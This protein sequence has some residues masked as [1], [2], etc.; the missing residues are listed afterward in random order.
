MN[1]NVLTVL[2]AAIL[3]CTGTALAE[4]YTDD[5]DLAWTD[6][7][8]NYSLRALHQ[9][10]NNWNCTHGGKAWHYLTE[11]TGYDNLQI[12]PSGDIIGDNFVGAV[13]TDEPYQ[14]VAIDYK[15]DSGTGPYPWNFALCLNLDYTQMG[16]GDPQY[17]LVGHQYAIHLRGGS[18]MHVVK[19]ADDGTEEYTSGWA[20]FATPS[21]DLDNEVW[22]RIELEKRYN[23]ITGVVREK[24][25]GALVGFGR[26]TDLG[27]EFTGGTATI[28]GYSAMTY[29]LDNFEFELWDEAPSVCGDNGTEYLAGDVDLD[30]YVNFDDIAVIAEQWLSS[31][32]PT[33][34]EYL[35]PTPGETSYKLP[36]DT[37][38][39]VD[40][41]L[42]DWPA[43]AEWI[44]LDQRYYQLGNPN[45]VT[46]A[47]FSARWDDVN[48]V[49]YAAVIV[50]ETVQYF[51]SQY[52]GSDTQDHIEVYSQGSGA[53][54][55][56]W[57][58]EFDVAQ[59]YRTAPDT[60]TDGSSVWNG[61]QWSV[62]GTGEAIAPAVG[63]VSEV[64]VTGSVTTYEL[65]IP[66]FD[67][68]EGLTPSGSTVVTQL[69]VGDVIGLD[70]IA[71]TIDDFV[72]DYGYL[73]ENMMTGKWNDA[74]QFA[75]YTLV[76]DL[77]CG[78]VGYATADIVGL[79]CG[80]NFADFVLM[81]GQWFNCTDP[82]NNDCDPYWTPEEPPLMDTRITYID[83]FNYTP[84]QDLAGTANWQQANGVFY[85]HTVWAAAPGE[86][87]SVYGET[88]GD[89]AVN[90]DAFIAAP[91]PTGNAYERVSLEFK[92]IGS[93]LGAL[94]LGLNYDAATV[95]PSVFWKLDVNQY[96]FLIAHDSN[97]YLAKRDE[98]GNNLY[99]GEWS[100][101][102]PLLSV[103]TWYRATLEKDGTTITAKVTSL[104]GL[105][106]YGQKSFEDDGTYGPMLEGGRPIVCSGIY[107]G[108]MHA[109]HFDNFE[110]E[111]ELE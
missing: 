9:V 1:K 47:K 60:D 52:Y 85:G 48:D 28:R 104:D 12:Y 72:T 105:T 84:P 13:H 80:V 79:D 36:H 68:Y 90:G 44:A 42:S 27:T 22:Y 11:G 73:S 77:A 108:S 17:Y 100:A 74:N 97:F 41:D 101:F 65:A 15:I 4:I 5:F 31:S 50:D 34:P 10:S 7:Y 98:Y 19:L 59:Q 89:G 53:G 106:T 99:W 111:I 45:D 56:G 82:N 26:I 87:Y 23:V 102:S 63:F 76:E 86:A 110:Y 92:W 35:Q 91:V 107:N 70:I 38:I 29:K 18:D 55:T 24:A 46:E 3:F 103:D 37:S 39:V 93:P 14:R 20:S 71:F 43:N 88:P 67:S 96:I 30:C 83:D 75:K 58:G 21:G 49:V 66:Q 33:S 62:W 16:P 51:A 32:D 8:E 78:D 54:G 25:T 64:N 6:A 94:R 61:G 57:S 69:D 109:P 95:D 2:I 40:G 81:A